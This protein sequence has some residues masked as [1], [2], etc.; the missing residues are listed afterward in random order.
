VEQVGLNPPP[1]LAGY[2]GN[3][4]AGDEMILQMLR[5]ALGPAPFL[6][7]PWPVG[8][9][10]VPRFHLWRVLLELGRSRALVLGGGELFQSRTSGRSLAYYLSLPL[11]A[12][13]LGRPLFGFSLALDP[14]L[15]SLGK[16]LTAI[17]LQ[18]ALGVWVR[19]ETSLNFLSRRRVAV[20]WMPDIVW[21]WPTATPKP[22]PSLRR[23]LWIPRFP[24]E[25]NAGGGFGGA[26]R[27]VS[28]HYQ[29]GFLPLHPMEDRI[30]L[31]QCRQ[32]FPHFHRLETWHVPG[33]IFERIA[34]YDLVVTMRYHG[35]IAAVLAGRPVIAIPGHGKVRDL[36]QELEVPM[37]EPGAVAS[38]DW[39]RVFRNAFEMGPRSP[40]VRPAQAAM[41]LKDLLRDLT[42]LS[43]HN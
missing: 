23:V 13:M 2:F 33:D 35:L 18:K 10:A 21:A 36:A 29:Y 20:R 28:P 24:S 19:E 38:T 8:G 26:L 6:S 34:A 31:A 11:I 15:G 39:A 16:R 43:L 41:A 22:S 37:I 14:D 1:L 7:G 3:G 17:L 12:R 9:P 30:P 5:G 4:N 32:G 25:I 40:G 42:A 27:S